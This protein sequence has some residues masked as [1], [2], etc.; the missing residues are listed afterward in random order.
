MVLKWLVNRHTQTYCLCEQEPVKHRKKYSNIEREVL[1]IL[2]GLQKFHNYCFTREVS[3]I[4]DFKLLVAI[5]KKEVALLSQR[6]QWILLR[7]HQ[8][9]VSFIY[10]PGLDLFIVVWLSRQNHKVNKGTQI[11]G[12]Q[13]NIDAIQTT[14]NI[15]DCMT[16]HKLK[17]AMSQ[18]EHLQCLKEYIIKGW[19]ERRDQIPQDIATNGTFQDDLPVI[20]GII[21]KE[22]V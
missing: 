6:I 18:D 12:M 8:Y 22:S 3:I 21:L 10:K 5:F 4:T 19:L 1:G 16:I 20:D 7:I 11:L 9:R 14:T 15:P 13:L 17:Q 2:H